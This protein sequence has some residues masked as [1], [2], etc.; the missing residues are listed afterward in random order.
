MK[1]IFAAV[2]LCVLT[3]SNALAAWTETITVKGDL[4]FRNEH[5]SDESSGSKLERTRHRLRARVGLGANV[6]D[7]LTATV[8]LATGESVT[9]PSSTNQ[10][11]DGYASKKLFLLDLAYLDWKAVENLNVWA[12]KMPVPYFQAGK[13]ELV[14]DNDL[15][16]EGL[17]VKYAHDFEPV[18]VW[19][20]VAQSWLDE[21]NANARDVVLYG[22][23]LGVTYK[24]EAWTVTTGIASYNFSQIKGSTAVST[25]GNTVTTTGATSTYDFD[26]KLTN[27]FVELG[28]NAGGLPLTVYADMVNNSE[29]T[30]NKEASLYG[31]RVGK[32]KE[33]G[34]WYA[35]VNYREVK[36][37]AVLGIWTE[38]D[39]AGGTTD[40][41]GY[42]G[43]VSYVAAQNTSIGLTHY[44]NEK[45]LQNSRA[46][47]RTQL[48]FNVS[49]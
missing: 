7:T 5:I 11:L 44:A 3:S 18:S 43:T 37:D 45:P 20:N 23:Q 16:P 10:T 15:T 2:A 48:D 36:R 21:T 30:D 1:A 22:G 12:G 8:R 46:Y 27:Y 9:D 13:S 33:V 42:K 34:D 31:V 35:D 39:F 25:N 14:F 29:A 49:F 41:K 47:A 38:S 6:T 24:Q 28:F 40:S 4:R 17:A 32:S 19:A 26:Y